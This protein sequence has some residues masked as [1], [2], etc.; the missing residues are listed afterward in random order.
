MRG[1]R[2]PAGRHDLPRVRA[3]AARAL[4]GC[5]DSEHLAA[6]RRLLADPDPDVRRAAARALERLER[7]LDL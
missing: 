4:G 6:V 5:G 1:R 2:R 7:R 3:T